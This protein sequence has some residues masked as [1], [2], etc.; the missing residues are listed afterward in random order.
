MSYHPVKF[1][2][3]CQ[4]CLLVRVQ[5]QNF[6]MAVMAAILFFQMAPISKETQSSGRPTT[7]L[8]FKS[9]GESVFELASGHQNV[10]GGKQNFEMAA[11]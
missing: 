2:I 5:K 3:D 6:K 8:S 10:D 9:I 7:L 11:I 1:Q 4:K